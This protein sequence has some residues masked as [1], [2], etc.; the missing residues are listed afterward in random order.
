M[1]YCIN[2]KCRQ[3]YNPD[4]VETCL[5]CGTSLLINNR[6]RINKRINSNES[7]C[8]EIL[9]VKDLTPNDSDEKKILKIIYDDGF[10]RENGER[11]FTIITRLFKREQDFLIE[12]KNPGIPIG[13]DKFSLTLSNGKEIHCLVMEKV[14][15]INLEQ[16]VKN[17]GT[18]TQERTLKWLKQIVD[19]LDFMHEEKDFFHRDIKPSN[20][21][22]R[23]TDQKLV[24]IDFGTVKEICFN[25]HGSQIN[26]QI[27]T[28]GYQPPEQ[29]QGQAEK[30]SDFY[31]LG[32][33]FVYLLT[34]KQPRHMEIGG[35]IRK[36]DKHIRSPI[37]QSLIKLIND[38]MAEDISK[39][40]EDTQTILARLDHIQEEIAKFPSSIS[41]KVISQTP[42]NSP[43]HRVAS[44]TPTNPPQ[45]RV[46][47]SIPT[48]P[49]QPE[50]QQ[51]WDLIKSVAIA[52]GVITIAAILIPLLFGRNNQAHNK[53]ILSRPLTSPSTTLVS[54][55]CDLKL[56]DNISCGEESLVSQ[57]GQM[58]DPPQEKAEGMGEI[59]EGN[60]NKAQELL[61][62]AWKQTFEDGKPDPETLIYLNNAK[63]HNLI[64]QQNNPQQK[65]YTIA[66]A[67]PLQYIQEEANIFNQGLEM[68][69]GVAQAQDEAI[70]E[71]GIY[72]QVA[73]ANDANNI[74][75]APEIAEQIGKNKGVL[76]VI[77]HYYSSITEIA[78]PKYQDNGLTLVSP[79]STS[80]KL[81]G[82]KN[83]YRI[84]PDDGA[85]GLAIAENLKNQP[86]PQITAI[87]WSQGEAF[88]ESLKGEV[89][90]NLGIDRVVNYNIENSEIFNLA[91]DNFN[92]E[93]ALN[94]AKKQKVT[95][96]ILIPD[97][98]QTKALTNAY[99]VIKANKDPNLIII[100]GD[101][102]YNSR[103]IENV[104]KNAAKNPLLVAVSWHPLNNEQFSKSA[105]KLWR[106]K[107]VSWLTATAYDATLVLTEAIKQNPSPSREGVKKIISGADFKVQ[108]GATGK[109]RFNGS[110]RADPQSTLVK[111]LPSC[112]S[113]TGY[114]FVPVNYS[115]NCI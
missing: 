73:I 85:T 107:D 55:A 31:S 52:S 102:L 28:P 5:S 53:D 98:G 95:A 41:S 91:S 48:S 80:L 87:F 32:R 49:P 81:S 75:K 8:T 97:G 12:N 44:S 68:L 101:T 108:Q 30:K 89:E 51:R 112:Q 114:R 15:G 57:S 86:N 76:G 6:Y 59:K 4:K 34:G 69:R 61:E 21:M 82:Q 66:I 67:A 64:N 60:Y 56:G 111:I 2:P 90:R 93:N 47:S 113:G 42:T 71:K 79:A 99:A 104:E 14:K 23:Q 36:W 109:I 88:S 45:H 50:N 20:I 96:I 92:V 43:Q 1:S 72:L 7:V 115:K 106:T 27:G 63:I 9:E 103:T 17:N 74:K 70:K 94:E 83:L 11:K 16:W 33:T 10:Q 62:K 37:S 105:E 54:E 100:G 29:S 40:P 22:R 19:I 38:L 18:I 78:L 24:L 46:A 35:E 65:V 39:R 26:T 77:G 25:Q 3:R 13:Y 110:D 84:A 58:K